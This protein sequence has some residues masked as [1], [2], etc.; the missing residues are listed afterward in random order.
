[1]KIRDILDYLN[2][3]SPL[4]LQE[5][6]DNSGLIVGH[7]ERSVE[8]VVV[9]LDLDDAMIDSAPERAL[10]VVH[11]PLI[12][13]KL[14]DLDFRRYPA[15]LIEK[16]IRKGQSLIAMHTNFDQTHLNRYVF[17][18]VLGLEPEREEPFL[19]EARVD[20]SLEELQGRLREAFGLKVLRMVAPRERIGSVAL[21]TGSG[22]SLMD[23]VEAECFLT[24][25]IKYHDAMKAMS[26][27]LM[28]VDIG[29]W[30]SERFFAELMAVQLK[31][32]PISVIISPSKNPFTLA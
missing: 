4:E 21:C 24:G 3:L 28:M 19:C 11:H 14:T 22:A 1:M 17:T 2:E 8:E 5:K 29:H 16:L 18:E 27:G 32:L 30:E 7:P 25:D 26:Q 13:G 15:D 20:W 31:T 6:W 10:F 12:F 23:R 9:S